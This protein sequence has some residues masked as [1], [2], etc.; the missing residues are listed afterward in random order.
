M[1]KVYLDASKDK[2]SVEETV[3][4]IKNPGST[5]M[6]TPQNVQPFAVFMAKAGIIKAAPVDWKEMFFPEAA[7]TPGS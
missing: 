4:L 3:E 5:F 2:L 6:L 7:A 1:A